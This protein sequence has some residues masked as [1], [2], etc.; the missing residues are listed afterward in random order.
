MAKVKV[1]IEEVEIG[2]IPI[3]RLEWLLENGH[4]QALRATGEERK[5]DKGQAALLRAG[6]A[7]LWAASQD[8][9]VTVDW[10][11]GVMLPEQMLEALPALMDCIGPK[12]GGSGKNAASP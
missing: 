6:A 11:R 1:G 10:V 8:A 4:V 9:K 12:E 5:S 2:R 3:G 7:L